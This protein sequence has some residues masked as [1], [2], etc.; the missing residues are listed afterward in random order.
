M[1]ERE[2]LRSGVGLALN[3]E[4][5]KELFLSTPAI[6]ELPLGAELI[7]LSHGQP[8]LNDPV[9]GNGLMSLARSFLYAG[10]PAVVVSLWD[11]DDASTGEFM[12][13]FYQRLRAGQSKQ[14]ALREAKLR[15]RQQAPYQH[16]TYWA[17]FVLI[18]DGEGTIDVSSTAQMV[19]LLSAALMVIALIALGIFLVRA[20]Q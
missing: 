12:K 4:R 2:P 15:L 14:A 19:V 6:L 9:N 11:A 3:G 16:P 7:T 18:G 20:K 10:T 8:R 5:A 13:T 1:D 17:R